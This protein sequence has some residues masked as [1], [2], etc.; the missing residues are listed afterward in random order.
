MRR[1]SVSPR[2]LALAHALLTA[3][4]L[5]AAQASVVGQT[6]NTGQAVFVGQTHL[7]AQAVLWG[8]LSS[9]RP[10]FEPAWAP[11]THRPLL[12]PMLC[13]VGADQR[14]RPF[15]CDLRALACS[16]KGAVPR[17]ASRQACHA[18]GRAGGWLLSLYQPPTVKQASDV[19]LPFLL[20]DA[21]CAAIC[22]CGAGCF[23]GANILA[24]KCKNSRCRRSRRQSN[25]L[26][27]STDSP[28]TLRPHDC[29]LHL[30]PPPPMPNSAESPRTRSRRPLA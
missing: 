28:K 5:D 18:G 16:R 29:A 11:F 6:H 13:L 1:S 12:N 9:L 27:S 20:A 17:G 8:R 30:K 15:S 2:C 19:V 14:V 4:A 10:A 22:F 23:R 25:I 24:W 21:F 3:Q 7:V 26:P